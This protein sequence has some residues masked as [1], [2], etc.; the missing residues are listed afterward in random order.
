MGVIVRVQCLLITWCTL[1]TTALLSACGGSGDP[2]GCATCEPAAAAA[3]PAT[4]R[5]T[6]QATSDTG[7]SVTLQQGLN[8]YLGT[9]DAFIY[10]AH[11]T[12][13]H[14]VEP[15]L[16]DRPTGTGRL[17]SLL[18]FAVMSSEGGPI[19]SGA[20]VTSAQLSIYKS[21]YYDTDYQLHPVLGH[22]AE[23]EVSWREMRRGVPWSVA[24][25]YGK[26]TD[27]AWQADA[28]ASAPWEP[29]WVTFD[30]TAGV[31]AI[32]KG[33]ANRGWVLTPVS[34]NTNMKTFNSSEYGTASLR[35]KLTVRYNASSESSQ[36][37]SCAT[38]GLKGHCV[39][40]RTAQQLEATSSTCPVTEVCR[41]LIFPGEYQMAAS[42][43]TYHHWYRHFIGIRDSQGNRPVIKSN[44]GSV[45]ATKGSEERPLNII[46]QDLVLA[47]PSPG[48]DFDGATGDPYFH[49][50]GLSWLNRV[51]ID[52]GNRPVLYNTGRNP[53][54]GSF[55][56]T[57]CEINSHVTEMIAITQIDSAWISDSKLV[58]A[59]GWSKYTV[60]LGAR[61]VGLQN[62]TT[63][64]G[65]LACGQYE[66]S[67]RA[68]TA[69]GMLRAPTLE[70][71][72]TLV[73]QQK[74]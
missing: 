7:Q 2:D 59:A 62:V 69:P 68:G 41:I 21:G 64:K 16:Y 54:G 56:C 70:W 19:P 17:R 40:V 22:W 65:P 61:S 44:I 36:V 11:D 23:A 38:L 66:I 4:A 34:G 63:E 48:V 9:T 50:A 25:A 45:F 28:L 35:P 24:G 1:S 18:K 39:E 67:C 3:A 12:L 52:T 32:A 51:K 14:G 57:Q 33:R 29:G 42:I 15:A 26:G 60:R 37:T 47:G 27:V 10:E 20:S 58:S 5:A 6:V 71:F 31:Q 46:L 43:F 74:P 72:E 55:W 30:V 53:G 49:K 8:G 13:N 73:A